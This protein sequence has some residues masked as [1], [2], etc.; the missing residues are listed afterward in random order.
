MGFLVYPEKWMSTSIKSYTRMRQFQ[1][2]S[3]LFTLWQ[4][5]V[6]TEQRSS[7]KHF[8][9]KCIAGVNMETFSPCLSE[10]EAQNQVV[11]VQGGQKSNRAAETTEWHWLEEWLWRERTGDSKKLW[12]VTA[13]T[14][15]RHGQPQEETPA[16]NI[17][18]SGTT[19]MATTQK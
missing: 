9:V 16:Q 1:D 17:S 6:G 11:A 19:V 5:R 12:P 4:V 7:G 10:A 8:E 3:P 13:S 18:F 15:F 14:K 2:Y